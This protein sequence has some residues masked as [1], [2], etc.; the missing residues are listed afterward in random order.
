M[1]PLG[2]GDDQEVP[3]DLKKSINLVDWR[4]F[5]D[6]NHNKNGFLHAISSV[7]AHKKAHKQTA[8]GHRRKVF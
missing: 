3:D 4:Q 7:T 5:R 1:H 6:F 8:S 2:L